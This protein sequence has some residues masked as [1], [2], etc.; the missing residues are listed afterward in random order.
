[1]NMRRLF[2]D[3]KFCSDCRF[4]ANG[5][6]MRIEDSCSMYDTFS[7]LRDSYMTLRNWFMEEEK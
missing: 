7:E 1:M 5:H 3:D 2:D 4:F 6:C